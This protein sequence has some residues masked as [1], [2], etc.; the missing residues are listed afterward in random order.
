MFSPVSFLS[1]L[2]SIIRPR[3]N[4]TERIKDMSILKLPQELLI[5]IFRY[6]GGNK[7]RRIHACGL[8]IHKRLHDA[9][10]AILYERF[11][12]TGEQLLLLAEHGIQH[13]QMFTRYLEIH[14][15]PAKAEFI[16]DWDLVVTEWKMDFN[17]RYDKMVP[18]LKDLQKRFAQF[19]CLKA[20]TLRIKRPERP[21][22]LHCDDFMMDW[23]PVSLLNNLPWHTLKVLELGTY[24]SYV[25][26]SDHFCPLLALRIPS[27]KSV[28][29]R[30]RLTC[31]EVFNF[32]DTDITRP[33]IEK[34]IIHMNLC[35]GLNPW[36]YAPEHCTDEYPYLD[37][38][39]LYCA[40]HE[41]AL[42]TVQCLP[43]LKSLV[44]TSPASDNVTIT[45]WVTEFVHYRER[46]LPHGQYDGNQDLDWCDKGI[47]KF[48]PQEDEGA[49]DGT[50]DT[51]GNGW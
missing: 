36:L 41:A 27:L 28:Q 23:S 20:L 33:S 7:L 16:D 32:Q 40:M 18:R 51:N 35:L 29:M 14:F 44:L 12:L 24:E 48:P 10:K 9:A 8:T 46:R 31:P 25:D 6:V 4:S 37:P 39:A 1:R 22:G 13:L 43:T 19:T 17:P 50:D 42:E 47:P 30:M 21:D 3:P 38:E 5:L 26:T 11:I 45:I 49:G 2:P 15:E 34:M